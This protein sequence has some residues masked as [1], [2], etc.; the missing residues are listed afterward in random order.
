MTFTRWL[1]SFIGFPLGGLLAIETVG[2]VDSA[3]SGAAAGLVA[4]GVLGVAQ[5]LA[6]RSRGIGTGWAIHTAVGVSAGMAAAGA[7]TQ[8]STG[9][10]QLMLVGLVAGAVVG[11]AQAPVL[12]V[13]RRAAVAWVATVAG[14]WSLGW[15]VTANVIVD[16]ERGYTT[17][18]A[19]GALVAT[20]ITGL[21]LR[22]IFGAAAVPAAAPAV[23]RK[24]AT[25]PTG[26]RPPAA[27]PA[28][29]R[30]AAVTAS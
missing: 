11:A 9:V 28:A 4:G 26:A 6:L 3:A 15:L 18:G 14:S 10:P 25:R 22:Q 7:I 2:G 16:A 1:C 30:A 27:V 8:G 19:S 13:S 23:G 21:A 20:A 17:F 5:G 12:R 24:G 29:A